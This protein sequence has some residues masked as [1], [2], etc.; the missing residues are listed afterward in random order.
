MADET[1]LA[2]KYS[3]SIETWR[4]PDVPGGT[5]FDAVEKLELKLEAR[6]ITVDTIVVDP[7]S[8]APTAN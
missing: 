6:K 3:V 2:G 5:I 1:G 8:K 7:V 4:I